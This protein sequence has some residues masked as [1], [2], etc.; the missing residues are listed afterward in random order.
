MQ[1]ANRPED[2]GQVVSRHLVDRSRRFTIGIA[3]VSLGTVFLICY[4]LLPPPVNAQGLYAPSTAR[5]QAVIAG[6]GNAALMIAAWNLWRGIR[7]GRGEFFEVREQ[8]VV[9]GRARGV[10]VWRW[11]DI[12]EVREIHQRETLIREYLGAQYLCRVLLS[13]GRRLSIT[14]LT[15]DYAGLG[16]A[17]VSNCPYL[18]DSTGPRGLWVTMTLLCSGGF[19]FC[20]IY[21][22]SHPDT[23]QRVPSNV[24]VREVTTQ[25][26][27]DGTAGLLLLGL[28]VTFVFGLTSLIMLVRTRIL[29]TTD[30]D[31]PR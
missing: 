11:S 15:S 13:D 24:G 16:D 29:S 23:E 27:S 19:M 8:G 1:S 17:L 3:G 5:Y 10:E 2:L 12:A 30:G 25:G 21:L 18:P 22:L 26:L 20:L 6:L 28:A 7:G 4:G 14:G 31:E 9:H